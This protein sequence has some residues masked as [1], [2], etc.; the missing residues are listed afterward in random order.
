MVRFGCELFVCVLKLLRNIDLRY[1][2]KGGYL[3]VVTWLQV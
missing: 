1:D 2:M 3:K